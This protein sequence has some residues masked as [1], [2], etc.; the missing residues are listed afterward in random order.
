MEER[1][2]KTEY[3]NFNEACTSEQQE[4]LLMK[5][6]SKEAGWSGKVLATSNLIQLHETAITTG[7]LC[8]QHFRTPVVHYSTPH[9]THL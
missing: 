4:F 2:A 5:R 9:D 7:M 8:C 1:K 6:S 3:A